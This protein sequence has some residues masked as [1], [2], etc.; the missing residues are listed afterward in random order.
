MN[1]IELSAVPRA[2]PS[3][4]RSEDVQTLNDEGQDFQ[5][6]LT[7]QVQDQKNISESKA[8]DDSSQESQVITQIPTTAVPVILVM[9]NENLGSDSEEDEKADSDPMQSGVTQDN[10]ALLPLMQTYNL[11]QSN[12]STVSDTPIPVLPETVVETKTENASLSAIP[13]ASTD[14]SDQVEVQV[15]KNDSTA[16]GFSE[17]FDS[18]QGISSTTQSGSEL[19]NFNDLYEMTMDD[20]TIVFQTTL[21][22]SSLTQDIKENQPVL[23]LRQ[24]AEGIQEMLNLGKASLNFQMHPENLGNINVRIVNSS[25]GIQIYFSAEKAGTSQF[26]ENHLSELQ[27]ILTNAGVSIGNMSVGNQQ[28]FNQQQDFSWLKQTDLMTMNSSSLSIDAASRLA[29]REYDMS[30][31][32]A[33]DFQA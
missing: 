6:S 13:I 27:D 7:K 23:V 21:K 11:V 8:V 4:P 17:E 31:M 20:N 2:A 28:Q 32:T 29:T 22:F 10:L 12:T 25:D 1:N 33:L 16:N 14:N 26:L 18:L 19:E 30:S 9:D 24:A 3:P 15:L 5:T